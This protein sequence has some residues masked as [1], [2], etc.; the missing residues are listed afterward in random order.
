MFA[1]HTK[2]LN[3]TVKELT[4]MLRMQPPDAEVRLVNRVILVAMVNRGQTEPSNHLTFPAEMVI[5]YPKD[6]GPV[7]LV[8]E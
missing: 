4:K 5:Q 6:D 1:H 8:A 2:G 7:Y 3:V